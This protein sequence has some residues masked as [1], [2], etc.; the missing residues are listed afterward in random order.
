M[1]LVLI[2]SPYAG[3]TALNERYAR[4]AMLDSLARGEAPFASHML[5]PQVLDDSDPA[6]RAQGM[7][8]GF[9]WGQRAELVAVYLDL[10]ISRGMEAGIERAINVGQTVEHRT[11]RGWPDAA[12]R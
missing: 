4:A 5:Y 3:N 6:E 2:E 9:A 1:K 12:H 11:V 8:A 10:G 7:A